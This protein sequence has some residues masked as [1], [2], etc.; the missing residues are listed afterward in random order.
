VLEVSSAGDAEPS[1]NTISVLDPHNLNPE[2]VV[3]GLVNASAGK[4][5]MEWVEMA[6][7]LCLDGAVHAMAT[8]P[9]NKEAAAAGG[10]KEIGH[11]ELI[12]SITKAPQVATMLM[13]GTLRVVHLTTHK[14]LRNACDAVTRENVLAKL[15]LT[16]EYFRQWGF[17]RPRIGVAALNPHSSDG[18][19]LG[20]EEATAIAPAVNEARAAR[21]DATGPVPADTVFNQAIDGMYDAVLC[22]YHDQGHIPVKVHGFEESVS[23]NLGF[24]LV[25]T[26]VDH[27]TAFDIA[28]K[29]IASAIS[30][31]EA[32]KLAA[33][34]A[35][36]KGLPR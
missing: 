14:S 13:S 30:M 8:A 27:G 23:I 3:P 10:Y 35:S 9:L 32:I 22:M 26:S 5:S 19:L 18:G 31:A 15:L 33:A 12:E 29:G 21:I 20:D 24:P 25:R 1:A 7:H 6:T 16:H 34:I 4:A 11:T 36:G 17:D 2:D 28:G